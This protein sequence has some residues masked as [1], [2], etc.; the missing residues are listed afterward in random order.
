MNVTVPVGPNRTRASGTGQHRLGE[1]SP[2]LHGDRDVSVPVCSADAYRGAEW[3]P[4]SGCPHHLRP[5]G[6]V[7]LRHHG[8]LVARVRA[9]G[10]ARLEVRPRRTPLTRD[11]P[12]FGP[13]TVVTVDPATFTEVHIDLGDLARRQRSGLRYLRADRAGA[14]VHLGAE[15][16]LPVGDWDD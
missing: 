10:V 5:H 16:P 11:D 3:V 15:Q 9:T 6:W 14:V 1:P 4:I 13:G 7:Y 12:G 8:A 2:P